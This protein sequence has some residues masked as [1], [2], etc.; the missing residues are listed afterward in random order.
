MATE[1]DITLSLT[2]AEIITVHP[3]QTKQTISGHSNSLGAIGLQTK[4]KHP[5]T[6]PLRERRRGHSDKGKERYPFSRFRWGT[7]EPHKLRKRVKFDN[8]ER[9][10]DDI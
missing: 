10:T 6:S 9:T 2:P 4:I 7:A 8:C 5:H 3:T 1:R